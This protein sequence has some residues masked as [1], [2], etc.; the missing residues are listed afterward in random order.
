MASD[1]VVQFAARPVAVGRE[2][3]AATM[4]AFHRSFRRVSHRFLNVW[5]MP[6]CVICEFSA[7]YELHGGSTL[8][9][10]SLTVLAPDGEQVAEM[11]VYLDESPL[12]EAPPAASVER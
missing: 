7:T 1:I 9:M 12:L 11:R 4:G 3:A 5:T 2:A 10:P 6:D 8:T